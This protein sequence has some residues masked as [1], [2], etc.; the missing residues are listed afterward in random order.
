MKATDGTALA[1]GK[2][3]PSP[4][5]R[6]VQTPP[7]DLLKVLPLRRI[8]IIEVV[9]ALAFVHGNG[10]LKLGRVFINQPHGILRNVESLSYADEICKWKVV[11]HC[12]TK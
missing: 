2:K 12:M 8:G 9:M 1:I 4:K 10:E 3:Y 7:S 6:L 5:Y 11:D